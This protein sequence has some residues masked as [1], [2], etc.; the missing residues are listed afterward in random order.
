MCDCVSKKMHIGEVFLIHMVVR[1]PVLLYRIAK[2]EPEP[3]PGFN[4]PKPENPGLENKR[5]QGLVS[6]L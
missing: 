6:T 3:K 2:L 5:L 4:V 1:L